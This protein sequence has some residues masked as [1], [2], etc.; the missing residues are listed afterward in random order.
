MGLTAIIP[1][2]RPSTFVPISVFSNRMYQG[3]R[4]FILHKATTVIVGWLAGRRCK[5]HGILAH[6]NRY[7]FFTVYKYV[8]TYSMEQSRSWEANRSLASPEIPR[9]L[10]NPKVHYHIYK[11]PPPVPI[12]SQISPVHAPHPT[13]WRPILILSS[14]IRLG[15]PSGLF[16][17]ACKYVLYVI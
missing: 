12:L 16:L 7:V 6:R 5:Y 13:S 17:S 9:I 3:C 10:W 8:L 14:H 11:C 4:N 15:L 2:P 1:R